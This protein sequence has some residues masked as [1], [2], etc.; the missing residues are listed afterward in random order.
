MQPI[1]CNVLLYFMFKI[2]ADILSLDARASE[3]C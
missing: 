3:I 2:A 1:S